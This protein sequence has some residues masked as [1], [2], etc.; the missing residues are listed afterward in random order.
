M[1]S[2]WQPSD[3]LSASGSRNCLHC[4]PRSSGHQQAAIGSRGVAHQCFAQVLSSQ[5]L[6]AGC[7]GLQ[8]SSLQLGGCFLES[9]RLGRPAGPEA[10]LSQ[11][12]CSLQ[13]ASLCLK[14]ICLSFG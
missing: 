7:L 3:Q 9:A 8:D 1:Q 12:L 2:C 4:H 5:R 14:L 6:L 11:R 10:Q 13:I